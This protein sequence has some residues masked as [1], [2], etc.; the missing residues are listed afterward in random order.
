[1]HLTTDVRTGVAPA[2]VAAV[3]DDELVP[4]WSPAS[5]I[6]GRRARDPSARG[7]DAVAARRH[8]PARRDAARRAPGDRLDRR[9]SASR[10]LARAR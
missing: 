10:W 8:R 2:D 1:V 9:G 5:S 4:G 6:R 3:L 7:G